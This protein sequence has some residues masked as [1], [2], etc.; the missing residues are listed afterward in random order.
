MLSP[1]L[2]VWIKE[3]NPESAAEATKLAD[4]YVAARKTGQ[5]WRYITWESKDNASQYLSTTKGHPPWWVSPL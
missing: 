5:P 1:E 3:R 2:Q 4:V